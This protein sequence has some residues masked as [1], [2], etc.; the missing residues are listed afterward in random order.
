MVVLQQNFGERTGNKLIYNILLRSTE[1]S[2]LHGDTPS[3]REGAQH[4]SAMGDVA[5]A[6][7]ACCSPALAV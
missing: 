1:S 5:A 3:H 6:L 4:R 7:P 2:S